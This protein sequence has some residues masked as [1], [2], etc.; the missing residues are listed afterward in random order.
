MK[1]EGWGGVPTGGR[2]DFAA[3]NARQYSAVAGSA[4]TQWSYSDSTLAPAMLGTGH[5]YYL[6]AFDE[7]KRLL[8]C[9]AGTNLDSIL[10]V[11]IPLGWFQPSTFGARFA[12]IDGAI[13]S[14]VHGSPPSS[15]TFKR[16]YPTR[17]LFQSACTSVVRSGSLCF[18]AISPSRHG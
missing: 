9:K 13:A 6:P 18:S 5:C 17:Q 16:S 8:H 1:L 15:A 14:D 11:F 3:G 4:L 12:I 2:P 7:G 10:A